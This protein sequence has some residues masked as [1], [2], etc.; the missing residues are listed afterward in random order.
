MRGPSLRPTSG[1]AL[2]AALA[3]FA[4]AA[5]TPAAAAPAR[6][7][8][9]EQIAAEL[10]ANDTALRQAIATWRGTAGDP[11]GGQAPDE[12]IGPS[13]VLQERVRQLAESPELAAETIAL[14][15]GPLAS[16][17]RALTAAAVKL[18]LLHGGGK[19]RKLK[20]GKPEPLADLVGH[21]REAE[22]ADN[23][24][25]HYLAAI[26]LV[27]TK[28][29]RVKSNSTAGAKGPMQFIPGT[30]KIYG[31]GGDIRDPHD[32]IRA[33][34]RLLRDRG[35]PRNYA[36]ALYAYNNSKLYVQAVSIFAKLIAR[37]PDAMAI[38]YCWGP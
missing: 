1:C 38:L 8:T 27:E 36:R 32:A 29:G 12:V 31:E 17:V 19:A 9:P 11:P 15:P 4:L 13:L 6:A 2:A 35:A 7:E 22:G 21:Y 24:E 28:F 37:D 18:A 33:A 26:N 16:D 10:G 25:V 30:W 5:S 34:A 20:V 3:V 14:L 23:V